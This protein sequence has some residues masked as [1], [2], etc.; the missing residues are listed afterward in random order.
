MQVSDAQPVSVDVDIEAAVRSY[1][2]RRATR[3]AALA[4]R[5]ARAQQDARSIV[6]LVAREL[7]PR[8]ILQWGSLIHTG[9]FSEIS[10][11]DIAIDGT[12]ADE[13]TLSAVRAAAEAMT[14]LHVDLVVLE[15]LDP[16]R[17]HLIREFGRKVWERSNDG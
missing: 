7:R 11:I 10:D 2:R 4:D 6:D 14:D 15:R 12:A 9:R 16:G 13:Q 1:Q 5:L 8:R 3:A 17:A